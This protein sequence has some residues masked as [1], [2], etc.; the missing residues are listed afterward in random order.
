MFNNNWPGN[1]QSPRGNFA[2]TS[3]MPYMNEK[4]NFVWILAD[5]TGGKIDQD[6]AC[7]KQS[8]L[9]GIPVHLEVKKYKFQFHNFIMTS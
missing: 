5:C 4:D 8:S 9:L 1:I 7:F 3:T 2:R 6:P